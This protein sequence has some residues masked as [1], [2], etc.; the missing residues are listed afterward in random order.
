MTK[1]IAANYIFPVTAAPIKN[2]ILH[3]DEN[4]CIID[5]IDNKG[6]L[7]E[8]ERTV[9]Y[10]G[11]LIPGLIVF[12]H[13]D[14]LVDPKELLQQETLLF[15][16]GVNILAL[17][18]KNQIDEMHNVL[19]RTY[20]HFP[21]GMHSFSW[22]DMQQGLIKS[23]VEQTHNEPD[24][25]FNCLLSQLTIKAAKVLGIQK[26]Y[27]SFEPGKVPG[28]VLIEGFDFEHF[29]ISGQSRIKRIV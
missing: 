18:E 28:V 11:V 2:G 8:Q 21:K 13:H 22:H 14:E 29:T 4:N 16:R 17:D 6:R 24:S 3:L 15:R 5:I 27:G 9:F 1:R 12:L 19:C 7:V 10:N 20:A 23:F 25:D 26:L